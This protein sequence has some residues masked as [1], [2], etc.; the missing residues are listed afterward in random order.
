VALRIVNFT[1]H[2]VFIEI[3]LHLNFIFLLKIFDKLAIKSAFSCHKKSLQ[4]VYKKIL[5][6]FNLQNNVLKK[7]LGKKISKNSNFFSR[8]NFTKNTKTTACF[9]WQ[10]KTRWGISFKREGK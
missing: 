1:V 5:S 4:V 2:L 6:T 10:K 8:L 9:A 7:S 3:K